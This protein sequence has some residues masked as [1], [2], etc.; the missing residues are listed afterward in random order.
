M[1]LA[2]RWSDTDEPERTQGIARDIGALRAI[3]HQAG[4]PSDRQ[5]PIERA[6]TPYAESWART[7][8]K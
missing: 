2:R 8:G 6:L 1:N 7:H 4:V 5:R 3:F